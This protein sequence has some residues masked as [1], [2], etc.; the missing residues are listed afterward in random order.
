MYLR[1]RRILEGVFLRFQ[2]RVTGLARFLRDYKI[3]SFSILYIILDA[4]MI[5]LLRNIKV[6]HTIG[7]LGMALLCIMFCKVGKKI[8]NKKGEISGRRGRQKKK[9]EW[10]G[11]IFE[12]LFFVI[13]TTLL[14]CL[15]ITPVLRYEEDMQEKVLG[16]TNSSTILKGYIYDEPVEKH[17]SQQLVIS[18]LEGELEGEGKVLPEGML[19]QVKTASFYKFHLGQECELRGTLEEP[20][21]F[22]GFDYRAYLRDRKI[23]LLM[24]NPVVK[25]TSISERHHGSILR[26]GLVDMKNNLIE[27]IEEVLNEPQSSLLAGIIFGEKKLFSK[28][29][30]E[31]TR[32]AG[33]SHIVA[34]SGYNVTILVVTTEKIFFFLPKKLRVIVGLIVIWLFAILSGLSSS[35]VRAC[36]MGSISLLAIIFGRSNTV[37]VAIPLASALFVVAQPLI[38]FDVGFLLSLS[39]VLGLTY[40]LPI[41]LDL[42]AKVTKKFQFVDDNILPTLSCTLGTLPISILTF[43]TFSIWAVP[44]NTIILPI[45]DTTMFLGVLGIVAWNIF[46]PLS[47]IFFTITNMQLKYFEFVVNLIHS[48]DWG[49]FEFSGGASKFVSLTFLLMAILF[50]IYLYPIEN[51]QYNY[52]LKSD[53]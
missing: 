13:I 4:V 7:L 53:S 2:K 15:R 10:I 42:K 50:I 40:I 47:Y 8:K 18:V 32:V 5:T 12:L 25:C 30:D 11:T 39:A 23:F 21:N 38:V 41:L 14:V 35:I 52:Y 19:V 6:S 37:H 28:F 29:F 26:H 43:N 3:I 20:E 45:I 27:I 51:E 34:A 1:I 22:E 33:L 16:F 44:S 9:K 46:K 36:I 31:G 24:N 49:Q 48:L 17:R